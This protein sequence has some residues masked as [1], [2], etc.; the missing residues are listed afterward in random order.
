MADYRYDER[1]S[2]AERR[3]LADEAASKL[4]GPGRGM[5]GSVTE[6]NGPAVDFLRAAEERRVNEA[7][8]AD[9]HR[10]MVTD[11]Q[12]PESTPRPR[13]YPSDPDRFT[14]PGQP[15]Q[16]P[17]LPHDQSWENQKAAMAQQDSVA[18][19][20]AQAAKENAMKAIAQPKKSKAKKKT[21]DQLAKE[22]EAEMAGQAEGWRSSGPAVDTS[23][24]NDIPWLRNQ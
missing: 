23:R 11:R 7:A 6:S 21:L 2:D 15:D 24:Q 9:A 1:M 4:M 19:A 17:A 13:Q 3:R 20:K 12:N 16:A 18:E 8:Q 14:Y 10:R 5:G 22:L